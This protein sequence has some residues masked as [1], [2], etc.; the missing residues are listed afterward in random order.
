MKDY[1]LIIKD[2][3][4]EDYSDIPAEQLGNYMIVGRQLINRLCPPHRAP[5]P[6]SEIRI[7][8]R[9]QFK[10]E[11]VGQNAEKEAALR[12]IEIDRARTFI[13]Q[14][15][16]GIPEDVL[17][18]EALV[19]ANEIVQVILE[20]RWPKDKKQAERMRQWIYRKRWRRI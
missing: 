9:E 17:D 4:E 5:L 19:L 2:V 8:L 11:P 12:S 3:L 7:A 6:E 1:D 16:P 20:G 10:S 15:V 13:E 18:F 14:I